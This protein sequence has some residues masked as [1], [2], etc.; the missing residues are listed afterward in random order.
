MASRSDRPAGAAAR[1]PTLGGLRAQLLK[2]FQRV[3]RVVLVLPAM[4]VM[5]GKLSEEAKAAWAT[6]AASSCCGVG[7]AYDGLFP[8][9]WQNLGEFHRIVRTVH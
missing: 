5:P 1:G 4:A 2:F 3:Q 9:R 8:D 6:A 7:A